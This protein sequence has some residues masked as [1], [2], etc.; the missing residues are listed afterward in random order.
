MFLF[1][2]KYSDLEQV[3]PY[4]QDFLEVFNKIEGTRYNSLFEGKIKGI[5]GKDEKTAIYL[6]QQLNTELNK[7]KIIKKAIEDGYK[8]PKYTGVRNVK[9]NKILQVGTDYSK[10]SIREYEKATLLFSE[11]GYLRAILP[12]RH[13]RTGYTIYPDRVILVK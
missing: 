7:E 4:Y 11:D 10:D 6:L 2:N 1:N 5:E 13:T 12:Y 9:Y 8:Y 3:R